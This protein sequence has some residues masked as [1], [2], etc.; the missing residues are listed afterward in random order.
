MLTA[1]TL[2]FEF[3]ITNLFTL[4]FKIQS[5]LY[6]TRKVIMVDHLSHRFIFNT[7]NCE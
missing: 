3:P 2:M 1:E 5:N 7:L 6:L 4:L